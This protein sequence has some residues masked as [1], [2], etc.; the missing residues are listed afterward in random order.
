MAKSKTDELFVRLHAQGLRKRTAKLMAQA[1]GRRGKQ[2]NAVQRTF[3]DLKRLVSE[4]EDRLSGSRGG[5]KAA[6]RKAEAK[7]RQAAAKKTAAARKQNA[8]RR[9]AAAK[10]VARTRTKAT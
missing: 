10:Q 8:Q 6:P 9:G 7:K 4:I 3:D 2:S 1:P 5:R